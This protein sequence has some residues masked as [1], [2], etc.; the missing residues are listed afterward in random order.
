MIARD[1]L[2]IAEGRSKERRILRIASDRVPPRIRWREAQLDRMLAVHWD[3]H[4]L[5]ETGH[6]RI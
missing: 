6:R 3:E 4:L 1:G 2:G 5:F